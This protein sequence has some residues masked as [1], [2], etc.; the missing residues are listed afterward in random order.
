MR[1]IPEG[2]NGGTF[3]V[4]RHAELEGLVVVEQGL[5]DDV[6]LLQLLL[7]QRSARSKFE[8]RQHFKVYTCGQNGTDKRCGQG[9]GG[10]R[11]GEGFGFGVDG[12]IMVGEEMRRRDG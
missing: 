11:M 12:G 1:P 10:G 4:D 8:R 9:R 6:E 3:P 7:A 5:Q 2:N